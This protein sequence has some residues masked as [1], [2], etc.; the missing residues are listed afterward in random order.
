MRPRPRWFY[1]HALRY[2][3]RAMCKPNAK[4]YVMCRMGICR[5]ASLSYFY[6]RAS[7]YGVT[8]AEKAVLRAR[9]SAKI[10]RIYRECGEEFLENHR[11]RLG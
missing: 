3:K 1:R 4:V 8:R 5:S 9:P 7:G 2:Y 11:Q 6:L 10:R